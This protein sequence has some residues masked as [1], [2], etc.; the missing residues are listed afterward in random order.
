TDSIN[1]LLNSLVKDYNN[2]AKNY[3]FSRQSFP[4]FLFLKGS[5]YN[6]TFKYYYINY[7]E[8]NENPLIREERVNNFIETGVLNE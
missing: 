3:N 7:G 8:I 6:F 1:S 2:K 5:I 4:N